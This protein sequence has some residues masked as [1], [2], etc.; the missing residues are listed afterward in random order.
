MGYGPVSSD[1]IRHKPRTIYGRENACERV[2]TE[3]LRGVFTII[4]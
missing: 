1:A 4:R 3:L 2:R